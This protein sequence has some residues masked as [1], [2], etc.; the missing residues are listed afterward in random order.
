MTFSDFLSHAAPLFHKL[1]LLTITDIYNLNLAI[2]IHN[3]QNNKFTGTTD[4]I[5]LDKFHNYNTR[6]SS[7][8]NYYQNFHKSDVG[9][10]LFLMLGLN[11]GGACQAI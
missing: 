10:L 6:L 4:L 11:S 7:N 3:F 8:N 2:M 1:Q 5:T 9:N